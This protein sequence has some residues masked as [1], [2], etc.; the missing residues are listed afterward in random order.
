[1]WQ[2]LLQYLKGVQSE[3]AKVSW[4]SRNDITGATTLVIVFSIAMAI[5]VKIFDM[6][7]ARLLG[8]LLNI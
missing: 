5:V 4:P 6:V 3:M 1:M 8:F 2:N 7:L